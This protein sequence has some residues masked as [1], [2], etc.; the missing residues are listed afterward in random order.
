MEVKIK[1]L[2]DTS[3]LPAYAH[4]GD[5]GMDLY[6]DIPTD[7]E[8]L[9]IPPHESVMIPCGFAIAIP[10][11]YFGAIYARS[12]LASKQGLRPSN[13]VGVVD[14]GYRNQV[15]VALHNDTDYE[16]IVSH[17]DRIAQMIVQPFPK[18]SLIEVNELD[19]TERGMG[20]FGSSGK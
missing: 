19:D 1:R 16:R 10:N 6:A 13:C 9:I 8:K 14:S 4:E 7:K 18:V 2:S 3:T 17:G 20:G 12:G 5:A 11:G 15:M